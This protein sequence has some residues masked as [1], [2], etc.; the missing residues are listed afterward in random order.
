MRICEQ[1]YKLQLVTVIRNYLYADAVI[2][3]PKFGNFPLPY[4]P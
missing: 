3:I 4:I 2:I 1:E